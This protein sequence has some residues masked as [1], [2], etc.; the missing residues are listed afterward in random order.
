MSECTVQMMGGAY[1]NT[2]IV[3][4]HKGFFLGHL[5]EIVPKVLSVSL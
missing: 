5:E 4:G 1:R 2:G 3:S